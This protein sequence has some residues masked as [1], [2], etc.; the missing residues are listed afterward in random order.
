MKHLI[1]SVPDSFYNSFIEFLKHIPEVSINDETTTDIPDWHKKVLDHRLAEHLSN[2]NAGTNWED[3]EKE[4]DNITR[5]M[6]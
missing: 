2:P 6:H 1:V 5:V 4:L 3:F